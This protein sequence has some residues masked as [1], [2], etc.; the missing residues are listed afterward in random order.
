MG[1]WNAICMI[2]KLPIYC[3]TN[4]VG[5]ILQPSKY[6]HNFNGPVYTT[7]EYSV[8]PLPVHGQYNDYGAMENIIET[9][10]TKLITRLIGK[11]NIEECMKHAERDKETNRPGE[12][13]LAMVRKDIFD[14]MVIN[15]N[16][17]DKTNQLVNHLKKITEPLERLTTMRYHINEGESYSMVHWPEIRRLIHAS[18]DESAISDTF[19]THY[20]NQ[21]LIVCGTHWHP[22]M[23]GGQSED[24]HGLYELHGKIQSIISHEIIEQELLDSQ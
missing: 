22:P 21:M 15:S 2:S 11:G 7:D 10:T 20:L 14:H 24:W 4:V 17:V 16:H 18:A 12:Y 1:S 19:L 3:G 13:R 23:S 8:L 5:F 9:S 6:P